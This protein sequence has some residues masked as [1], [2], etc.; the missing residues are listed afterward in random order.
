LLS[1]HDRANVC[2]AEFLRHPSLSVGFYSLPAGAV[3]P[4]KPHAEDE[5]YYIVSGRGA[6]HVDGE[7]RLVQ[8]GAAIFV[9]AGVPHRFHSIAEDM[10]VLVFFAPAE[11]TL[12][13]NATS[14][15]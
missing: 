13:Q 9:A 12:A 3:D 4:Q 14:A 2:Y 8:A 11:Y 15:S 1:A 5:V 7:D 10:T 6:I